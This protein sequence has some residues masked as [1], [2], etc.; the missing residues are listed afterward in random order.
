MAFVLWHAFAVLVYSVPRPATDPLSGWVRRHLL[1]V[2]APYMFVTSQWQLWNLFAPDP[3]R[4]VTTYRTDVQSD[5]GWRE[6]E[7]VGPGTFSIWR[8]TARFQLMRNL[9]KDGA[10]TFE[11]AEERYLELVC[12]E[13]GLEAGTPIRLTYEHYLIPAHARRASRAWW[14]EWRPEPVTN[15]HPPA[16]C[17]DRP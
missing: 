5:G 6:L 10:P 15:V 7:T 13:H 2:V 9:L 1:P 11:P 3:P 17:P 12:A 16:L 14:N 8:H 4:L